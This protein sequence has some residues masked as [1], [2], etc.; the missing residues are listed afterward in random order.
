MQH[1]VVETARIPNDQEPNWFLNGAKH[2]VH[3]RFGF[4]AIDCGRMVEASQNW[5]H[6][7]EQHTCEVPANNNKA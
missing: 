6:V 3:L 5:S 1:L 2:H 4:G 7:G